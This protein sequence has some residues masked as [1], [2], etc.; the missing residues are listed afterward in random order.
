MVA[1]NKMKNFLYKWLPIVFG[2]HCRDD[3]SFHYKGKKFPICARCTGELFGIVFSIFSCIFF[4]LSPLLIVLFMLPMIIDGT[5]QMLTSYE[6]N[7]IKRFVTG[8]LFGYALF[9]F[10]AV[11]TV[12]TFNFGRQIGIKYFVN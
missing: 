10:V 9:M 6:S 1:S 3:R 5:V 7:N 8:F 11:S 2:C 12:A 4:K